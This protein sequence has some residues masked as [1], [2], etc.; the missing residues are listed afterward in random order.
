M[1]DALICDERRECRSTLCILRTVRLQNNMMG[2]RITGM[3]GCVPQPASHARVSHLVSHRAHTS[4]ASGISDLAS[5]VLSFPASP[6]Q[7]HAQRRSALLYRA[8]H[9][10]QAMRSPRRHGTLGGAPRAVC[11]GH[12]TRAPA[13]TPTQPHT[14]LW[15]L[16]AEPRGLHWGQSRGEPRRIARIPRGPH[17]VR[18]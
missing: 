10:M 8:G 13:Q 6:T 18:L 2:P 17:L 11:P 1:T 9:C 14:D 5:V 16:S 12:T 15:R 3:Y 4:P 7:T